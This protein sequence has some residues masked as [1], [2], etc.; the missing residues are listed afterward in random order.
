MM[1]VPDNRTA[2]GSVVPLDADTS[3]HSPVIKIT[4]LDLILPAL[5]VEYVDLLKIDTEGAEL[6]VLRGAERTL[7]ITPHII[8]EYHSRDLQQQVGAF[9]GSHG[10]RQ[11]LHLDTPSLPETGVVY[12]RNLAC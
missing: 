7:Q 10:F 9:F 5:G 11:V 8:L 1:R 2:L 6:A 4:S 3:G 12:A